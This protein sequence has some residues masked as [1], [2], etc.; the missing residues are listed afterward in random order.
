MADEV[1]HIFMCLLVI[2]QVIYVLWR[3]N[4]SSPFSFSFVSVLWQIQVFVHAKY[5]LYHG[6]TSLAP[7]SRVFLFCFV[8]VCVC[9]RVCVCVCVVL[10]F[11][12]W[13]YTLSHSNSP[14]W[15]FFFGSRIRT[16]GLHLEPLQQP[17]F[18]MDFFE[19]GSLKLFALA[20][21][22]PQS[23]WSLSPE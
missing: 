4:Y 20:G 17:F 14:F 23:S 12:L 7:L 15:D 13:A 2:W 1:E 16:Q 8:C 9:A 22:E 19:I 18:V 5:K 11:E 3:N 6:T 21:F 10:G